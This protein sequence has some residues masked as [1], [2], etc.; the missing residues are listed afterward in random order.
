MA[1]DHEAGLFYTIDYNDGDKLK[2]VTPAGVITTLGT[3]AGIDGRGMAFDDVNNILYGTGGVDGLYQIDVLT[4]T[5]SLIG[6]M[7]VSAGF[8][9]LAY[10]NAAGILYFNEGNAGNLY[11]VN[12]STGAATLVGPNGVLRIDG[13]AWAPDTA[14][15]PEPSTLMLFG[16]G[17]LA[18][19]RR[20]QSRRP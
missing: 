6:S 13:L 18:V 2:S 3:G 16:A 7:G 9:G 1:A 8:G 14:P 19:G 10:D 12:V 11:T 5:A 17:L 20:R 15:V 4:G